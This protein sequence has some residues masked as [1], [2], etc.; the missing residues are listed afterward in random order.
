M[1][2]LK[3]SVSTQ[4]FSPRCCT[5]DPVV[6]LWKGRPVDRVRCSARLCGLRYRLLCFRIGRGRTLPGPRVSVT[7]LR[8]DLPQRNL[9]LVRGFAANTP[10][11]WGKC[12]SL[13]GHEVQ[14]QSETS[15][16]QE[17]RVL[18]WDHT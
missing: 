12:V 11:M 7:C 10:S 6:P 1:Y 9:V 13:F 17:W 16:R 8:V 15:P 3:R 14:F 18:F 2:T 5:A 4:P